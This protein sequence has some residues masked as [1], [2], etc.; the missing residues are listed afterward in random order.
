[1]QGLPTR[2]DSQPKGRGKVIITGTGRAGTTLLVR[3]FTRLG[4]DTGFSD[5][6]LN[7]VEKEIGRAGLELQITT[8]TA[9]FLPE[10]IK[11][12]L[13]TELLQTVLA[14]RWFSVDHAI[15][16]V[17]SLAEAAGS[18]IT[19]HERAKTRNMD[20][21]FV[22]G[23]LLDVT[24]PGDQEAELA[25]KFYTLVETLVVHQ[26][27]T[28]F[29]GFPRFAIDAEYF[30]DTMGGF[31]QGCFGTSR[32]DLLAAHAREINLGFIGSHA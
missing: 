31:L 30:A 23:G 20:P 6:H 27:P 10:V 1:M 2:D 29:L 28:T 18:R 13:L 4:L 9:D 15:I 7:A 11:S 19:V 21:R 5:A 25:R 24:D 14:E 12:P 32:A 16:P 3:I 8:Q 17:R 22:P 26:I